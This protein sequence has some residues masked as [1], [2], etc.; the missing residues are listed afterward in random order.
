MTMASL[1][2]QRWS[3]RFGYILA[4][5]GSAVGLG[6]IWKFPYEVGENGGGVFLL[7]YIAG[8]VIVVV[9]LMMAE[10]VIGRRGR[11]DAAASIARVAKA[12]GRSNRWGL[13][14]VFGI[15][16]GFVVL[17]Y[18]AVIAGMTMAYVPMALG[19]AFTQADVSTTQDL[20]DGLTTAPISLAAWQAAFLMITAAIVS[21]GIQQGIEI[22]CKILMPLLAVLMLALVAFAMI[23]GDPAGAAAFI[24]RLDPAAL[25]ARTAVE[26]LGLAFFSI[27]VGMG[28]MIT[29][30]AYAGDDFDLTGVTFATIIGDTLIS[31]LAGMAIFPIVFGFGLDPAAGPGLMFLTLPIAFGGLPFGELVGAGFFVLLFVAGLA[32]AISL[33]EAISAPVI[34]LTGVRRPI[35]VWTMVALAWIGGLPVVLSFGPWQEVHPLSFIAGFSTAGIFDVVDGIASNIMLPL[36][37]LLVAI[38]AGWRMAPDIVLEELRRPGWARFFRIMLPVVVPTMIVVMV[39]SGIL[40]E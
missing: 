9:P 19:G 7:F 27:G 4:T 40:I 14:G 17:T 28:L 36:C 30:A 37:G 31:L 5:M 26:A 21:R 35:V 18:Y 29:Y 34:R 38:F 23:E 22:A 1:D 25:T 16:T 2:E 13:I 20:F 6:S 10:F 39:L 11:G 32:S 3:S 15:L 12:G 33:V 24:F 8:L